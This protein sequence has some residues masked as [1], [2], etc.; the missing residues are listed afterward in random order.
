MSADSAEK[1]NVIQDRKKEC[2]AKQYTGMQR[3][4]RSN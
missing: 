2:N 1:Y 4:D 3:W